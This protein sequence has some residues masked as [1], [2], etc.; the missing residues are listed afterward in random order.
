MIGVDINDVR[1]KNSRTQWFTN[2][3]ISYVYNVR[4]FGYKLSSGG[5]RAICYK[6]WDYIKDMTFE[7]FANTSD[8]DI[9]RTSGRRRDLIKVK[10]R[11]YV[12]DKIYDR[13]NKGRDRRK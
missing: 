7:E 8:Y 9:L 11:I 4:S 2:T 10:N 6:L 3:K 1:E 13:R 5:R 12:V